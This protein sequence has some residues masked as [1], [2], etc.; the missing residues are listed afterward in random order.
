M[1]EEAVVQ[2]WGLCKERSGA[3]GGSGTRVGAL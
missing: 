1:Q 3:G 2:E